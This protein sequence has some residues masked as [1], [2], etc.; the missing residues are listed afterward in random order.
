[1]DIYCPKC[2]EPWDMDC[3]HEEAQE[4][5]GVP[6]YL[7]QARDLDPFRP[8]RPH[9]Q[10]EKNPAYNGDAYGEHYKDVRR[11]F[12]TEGCGLALAALTGGKPCQRQDADADR[13]RTFGLT[14][15]EAA[16]A[17]YEVLGDDLD[18]AAAMLEDL[19]Y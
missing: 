17:A 13:D 18:G 15:S 19:G 14:S 10:Q 1:M 12:Q 6:Y 5:Y 8:Y 3:L 2:G 7:D 11:Q 16:A 9:V 4:R